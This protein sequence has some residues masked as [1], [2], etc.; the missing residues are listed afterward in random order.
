MDL[1]FAHSGLSGSVNFRLWSIAPLWC[2]LIAQCVLLILS[3]LRR[4]SRT[5]R[6]WSAADDLF[7]LL[8]A[9]FVPG[10]PVIF[11]SNNHMYIFA[12]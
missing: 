10:S 6:L 8:T 1:I 9:R 4:Y 3:F 2:F 7:L 11:K 5:D 12:F